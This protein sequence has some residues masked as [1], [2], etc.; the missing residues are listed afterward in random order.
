MLIGD[1]LTKQEIRAICGSAFYRRGEEYFRARRVQKLTYDPDECRYEAI[2]KGS[3]SYSVSI[4]IDDSEDYFEGDCGC[5]A[6]D[7]YYGY[8]KHIAAVLLQIEEMGRQAGVAAPL[9]SGKSAISS[10]T[11]KDAKKTPAQSPS[12]PERDAVLA[13]NVLALFDRQAGEW[14][15]DR[16]GALLPQPITEAAVEYIC[17]VELGYRNTVSVELKVGVGRLYVVQKIKDFLDKMDKRVPVPFSKLFTFDSNVHAFSQRDEAILGMLLETYRNEQV[18]R[19]MGGSFYSYPYGGDRALYIPP[20]TMNA[21]LPLL[22]DAG[23]RFEMAGHVFESLAV[24]EG[25]V[26]LD[27]L[28]R[29]GPITNSYK[30]ELQGITNLLVAPK[31]GFAVTKNG[32]LYR[33]NHSLLKRLTDLQT[34]L[35]QAPGGTITIPP[36]QADGFFQRVAPELK[37]I[38]DFKVDTS[39][40]QK[41][42][43]AP[44]RAQVYIDRSDGLIS[45]KVE[46]VYGESRFS[47]L[48]DMVDAIKPGS[49]VMRETEREKAVIDGLMH[50]GFQPQG[51]CYSLTGEEAEYRLLFGG[52][53][54]LQQLAEVYVTP[55][56]QA[57]RYSKVH[58]P[59]ATVDVDTAVNWLE[60]RFHLDGVEEKDYIALLRSLSEKKKYHRLTSG[61]FISL[62]EEGFAEIGRLFEELGIRKSEVKGERVKLPVVRGLSLSEQEGTASGSVKLGKPL[63]NLLANLRNPDNLDFEPPATLAPLLRD[64][65]KHGFQWMKTLGYYGFGGILADDMGLGKTLQS[66]SYIVAERER[67]DFKANPVLIVCPASLV[68]NWR[69]EFAKFAPQLKV[70]VIEGSKAAREMMLEEAASADVLVTSYPLLRRDLDAYTDK[71]FH[72]LFLDEAQA[73]KN[74]ATQTAQAV[75]ALP[76]AQRFA[77]TGT[78]VENRLE[79]LWSIFDAV[80]PELFAGRRAFSDLQADQVARKVRPF[81]LRRLK[82]DVLTELPDKIETLQTSALLDEQK[83]LYMAYL[84][85]L[86]QETSELLQ[87]DGFQKSRMK[88]LAGLTRLRQ[89]CCHPSLFL[90]DYKGESGKFEQLL[91][92]VEEC[93]NSGKRMLIF[94]QFTQMLGIMREE[95]ARRQWSHYYLDGNTKAR[96][97]VELCQSFNEGKA[98]IFLISLKAGGTGL[99]LTG[100]DTVI[101][102]DLWWNPAVEQQAADRAHR[103]GQKNVVQ[104]IRLITEGTIEEKMHE[105]QQRKKDLID[106]VVQ[107]GEEAL[108]SLTEEDIRELLTL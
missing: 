42:V 7:S 84:M 6:Y 107:P 66:I 70:A 98:D 24:H 96:E 97:R 32:T 73:I 75:K 59:R 16:N 100:A 95:F 102:Y 72:A 87:E 19:E 11:L 108:T 38:G 64:Y 44:L 35:N 9:P 33:M 30:L 15:N 92:L 57:L 56:V 74:N 55:A 82:K 8:C 13:R 58:R 29:E 31:Y 88:I 4:I 36:A 28:L 83:K 85:K 51:N 48:N 71:T 60:V 77:L 103:I 105:L 18:Y 76:A 81:L 91:Q 67:S 43:T 45:A 39:I 90:E 50:T 37:K 62:E 99:N 10:A 22:I 54:W 89:L 47:P 86:K 49:I 80:F 20:S 46:F 93:L 68:Y 23:A 41:I 79:E 34:M 65:Q 101:L 63:R 27:F 52:L 1:T 21:M 106:S 12:I 53:E 78:P 61:A 25:A 104:V 14:T 40:E 94:S 69:N 2:V 5:P 17:R 26:P 3:K